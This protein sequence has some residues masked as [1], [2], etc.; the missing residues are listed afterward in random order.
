MITI[1]QATIDDVDTLYNFILAI[2]DF[3]QQTHFVETSPAEIKRA[4]FGDSPKFGAVLA[5]IDGEIAGYCSYTWNYSIWR[6]VTYMGLDDLYVHQQ[7]R[8]Q[9]VGLHLMNKARDICREAGCNRIRWEVEKDN[10]N[11]I[12]FYSKLGAQV[13]IK[14]MCRWDV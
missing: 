2:A 11:A 5:E 10:E 6:G 13:D 8:S 4:G 12:N 7:Y 14:G 9:K 1:R 3:H